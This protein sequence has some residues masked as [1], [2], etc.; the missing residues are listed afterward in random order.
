MRL[1]ASAGAVDM[2]ESDD[3]SRLELVV[4]GPR[5]DAVG[6]WGRWVDEDHVAVSPSVLLSLAGPLAADPGW[7]ERFEGM[8]TRA[9]AHSWVDETGDVR[10]HVAQ[11]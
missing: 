11:G 6:D 5:G 9:A 8:L 1:H 3:V 2:T 4:S 10:M 7:R